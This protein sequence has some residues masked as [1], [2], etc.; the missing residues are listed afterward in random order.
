M[1]AESATQFA[2]SVV[3]NAAGDVQPFTYRVYAAAGQWDVSQGNSGACFHYRT[4]G[5]AI[6]AARGAARSHWENCHEPSAVNLELGGS[7]R[8]VATYGLR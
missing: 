6:R 7:V 4:R 3:P 8:V 5:G 2:R 1:A